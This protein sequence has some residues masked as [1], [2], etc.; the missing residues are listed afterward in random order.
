MHDV[1]T[2]QHDDFPGLRRVAPERRHDQQHKGRKRGDNACEKDLLPQDVA[3]EKGTHRQKKGQE[4]QDRRFAQGPNV[5]RLP[6]RFAAK[7]Q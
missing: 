2:I 5:I 6:D 3:G 7:I 4:N 1:R